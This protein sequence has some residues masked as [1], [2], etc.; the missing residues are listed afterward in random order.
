MEEEE[1]YKASHYIF[2]NTPEFESYLLVFDTRLLTRRS[3]FN[4]NQIYEFIVRRFPEWV[5]R[6][7]WKLGDTE[8]IPEWIHCLSCGMDWNV[9]YTATYTVNNYKFHTENEG[10]G[11]NTINCH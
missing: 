9:K 11:R 3:D 6:H 4:E 1:Y 10:E 7:V 8:A 5:K 2:T